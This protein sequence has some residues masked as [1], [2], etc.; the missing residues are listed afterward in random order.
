[1]RAISKFKKT[2]FILSFIFFAPVG[3]YALLREE[4]GKKGNPSYDRLVTLF[5]FRAFF[6]AVI[7]FENIPIHFFVTFGYTLFW[8]IFLGFMC[9]K[10]YYK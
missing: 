5:S 9:R 1:M 7:Y 3:L 8:I 2:F 6:D 4:K 10:I